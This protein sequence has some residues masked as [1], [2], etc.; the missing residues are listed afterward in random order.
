MIL[1]KRMPP[2]LARETTRIAL[3]VDKE[4]L[5]RV[6]VWRRLQPD[7]MP[8]MSDAIRRLVDH[9]LDAVSKSNGKPKPKK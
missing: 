7:P 4:W 6:A 5:K 2:K 9:A 3:V 8:T 1:G